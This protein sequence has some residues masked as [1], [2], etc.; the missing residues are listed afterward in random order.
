MRARYTYTGCSSHCT[1]IVLVS[2]CRQ[3]TRRD[4]SSIIRSILGRNFKQDSN[5]P[6]FRLV[7][8]PIVYHILPNQDGGGEGHPSLTDQQRE[9][10]TQMTNI[11][12]DIYDKQTK[13]SVQFASFA[14]DETITHEN[15]T[16]DRDC[17]QLS[18]DE[19]GSIVTKAEEWEYKIH[20][21][22]CESASFSGRANFPRMY[23]V[24]D[25]L[26]NAIRIDYRAFACYDDDGN[27][28]CELT[29][30]EEVSHSRWWR[31]RSAVVAHEIAHV[32]GLLHTFTG[33]C[34]VFGAGDGVPDTPIQSTDSSNGCPG[35]LPYDRD[36]DLFD[37]T[38]NAGAN[39]TTCGAQGAVCG[40]GC[41]SCCTSEVD[42]TD[43]TKYSSEFESVT[44]GVNGGPY[45]CYDNMPLD[46]CPNSKGIDPM[47]NVMSYIPDFCAYEFTSGQMARMMA[48]TR[49]FKDYIYCNYAN[50]LDDDKC[51]NVPCAS[52]AT[53]PNC[54]NRLL[55]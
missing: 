27:F 22:V 3:M 48:Q 30:G 50:I 21:I 8:I 25:P 12:F 5:D 49:S 2:A 54:N 19:L 15:F 7:D 37:S 42:S 53:S 14:T 1:P 31:T 23:S 55:Q 28:L 41:A 52:T 38:P 9:H 34:S 47:T 46:T 35:L 17:S 43:C 39:E 36:R 20:M 18:A 16:V 6:A 26:H 24:D 40:T 51:G 10:T 11:L 44:E 4:F 33:K 13:T 45:C 32:L 29:N